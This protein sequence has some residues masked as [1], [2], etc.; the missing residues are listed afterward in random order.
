MVHS[1]WEWSIEDNQSEIT[2]EA[3]TVVNK[4]LSR[5]KFLLLSLSDTQ[6]VV[7]NDNQV[8][9]LAT[10]MFQTFKK[11]YQT[12][13]SMLLITLKSRRLISWSRNSYTAVKNWISAFKNAVVI[14]IIND[15]DKILH[16]TEFY[17]DSSL[18]IIWQQFA[19]DA[20]LNN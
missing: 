9:R 19:T 11:A 13:K 3:S 16:V 6:I 7:D 20:R 2:E 10:R 5:S 12:F 18:R 1:L 8:M 15:N 4:T 14:E 17:L